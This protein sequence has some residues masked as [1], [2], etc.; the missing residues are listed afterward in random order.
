MKTFD[1]TIHY[2]V[3]VKQEAIDADVLKQHAYLSGFQI[4]PGE[5]KKQWKQ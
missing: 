5:M 1:W 2:V 3:I 4:L